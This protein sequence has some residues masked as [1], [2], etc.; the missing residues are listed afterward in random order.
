M[1]EIYKNENIH[2]KESKIIIQQEESYV[3]ASKRI[4]RCSQHVNI[5]NE[6]NNQIC[7]IKK[8]GQSCN[9]QSYK[10]NTDKHKQINVN[11]HD[12]KNQCIVRHMQYIHK[13]IIK[14]TLIYLKT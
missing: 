1:N 7:I 2:V 6:H 3:K 12:N 8:K 5:A 13:I 14:S 10:T 4:N 9:T 11:T